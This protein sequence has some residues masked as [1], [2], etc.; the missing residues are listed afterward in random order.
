M[1]GSL[2]KIYETAFLLSASMSDS[3]TQTF[4]QAQKIL[5]D[6][7]VENVSLGDEAERAAR[8]QENAFNLAAAAV[9][10]SGLTELIG[11]V[12][13]V[14]TDII[15]TTMDFEYT[16]SAVQAISDAS[17]ED[18]ALLEGKARQLGE[19]TV[20]T[21][22]QSAEAM[23]F[24]A[25]AGWDTIEMLDGM[26]GVIALAAA[27][28]TDLAETSSIVADTLA[29]FGMAADDTARLAD[30]LAQTASHTNTN[31]SLMGQTFQNAAAVAGALGF[32]VEDV[33]VMLGLMANAGVKGSRAGTTLRNIFNGLAKD[34]TLTAEAF[35]E[36]TF[37][38]F[39]ENG[40]S[41]DLI[42]V[43]RE[44][45]GYFDQ[46]NNQEK[47]LNAEAIAGLRGYNGLLA[48]LNATDEEFEALYAD[49]ENCTGAA[50]KMADTRLD[51][52]K[53]DVT[54]LNS[55]WESLKITL[56]EDFQ[57]AGRDVVETLTKLTNWAN[58]FVQR[59]PAVV[60]G[61]EGITAAL[62]GG[63]A[64]L[65]AGAAMIK[66]IQGLKLVVSLMG[67]G[68]AA[69]IVAGVGALVGVIGMAAVK[70]ADLRAEAEMLYADQIRA[71]EQYQEYAAAY[72]EGSQAMQ[73]ALRNIEDEGR[74]TEYLTDKLRRLM[75]VQDKT[76]EQKEQI[77]AVVELLNEAVPDLALAYDAEADSLNLTAEAIRERARA[78]V[79]AEEMAAKQEQL[80]ER[81]RQESTLIAN[82]E[83][84]RDLYYQNKSA[85][86]E[87]LASRREELGL[88]EGITAADL[89]PTT[90][91]LL[92]DDFEVEAARKAM[93]E[94]QHAMTQSR[95]AWAD[96]TQRL[97]KLSEEIAEYGQESMEAAQ[98]QEEVEQAEHA[99]EDTGGF[100]VMDMLRGVSASSED[101]SD[102]YRG[103]DDGFASVADTSEVGGVRVSMEVNTTINGNVTEE[104]LSE[105]EEIVNEAKDRVVE[106]LNRA[107]RTHMRLSYQSYE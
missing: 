28:G 41:K 101:I 78:E 63:T 45:R 10:Q 62:M 72:Q 11:N 52:L 47:Y 15:E 89:D 59:H 8:R 65:A 53:G 34:A 48:I 93:E 5:K 36:V 105:F 84:A 79:Y 77:L 42:S 3:Y 21:A 90:A 66:A 32:E 64:A 23:T 107:T 6:L 100:D 13:D 76:K 31:V 94:S 75:A 102:A 14:Y 104:N 38:M 56:G 97:N 33:S 22:Q 86:E 37:S 12:R 29:G 70:V 92:Y 69:P 20:Y 83:N 80:K 73:E 85:Y 26:D 46:M 30:V 67:G 87:A 96:N 71:A 16:I 54:L 39:D 7:G 44:L 103:A 35:G 27:S 82:F 40:N 81:T 61:I 19:T 58:G 106:E 24:M 91:H 55:A 49:I 95:A 88:R 2:R 43:V 17:A 4:D 1:A 25:Q 60:S 51:N 68:A 18:I 57:P 9:A 98:A 99:V 50:Q 74:N